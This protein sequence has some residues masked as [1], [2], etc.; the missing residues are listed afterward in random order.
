[1]KDLLSHT[2]NFQEKPR[3]IQTFASLEP[4][5]RHT[6]VSVAQN[7]FCVIH[8]CERIFIEF[9]TLDRRLEVSREGSK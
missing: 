3:Q 5:V 8:F 2:S 6:R 1:M 7:I 4:R 9:M